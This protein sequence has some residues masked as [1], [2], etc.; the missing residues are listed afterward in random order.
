M[1][2]VCHRHLKIGDVIKLKNL[3][4]TIKR[5]RRYL[6]YTII[7]VE[8][9]FRSMRFKKDFIFKVVE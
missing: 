9:Y 5:I 2:E 1:I 8:E 6:N 7:N 3:K 4:Y